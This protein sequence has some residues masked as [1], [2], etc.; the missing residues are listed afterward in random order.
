MHDNGPIIFFWAFLYR[1]MLIHIYTLTNT[2]IIWLCTVY[3]R[4]FLICKMISF[5][6]FFFFIFFPFLNVL[7]FSL[8]TLHFWDFFFSFAHFQIVFLLLLVFFLFQLV[9][10]WKR[11]T[12]WLMLSNSIWLSW[13]R[14][15]VQKKEQHQD[16]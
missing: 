14:G 2:H 6:F 9:V 5:F 11:W 10:K 12:A 16:E 1:F 4:M 13:R 7:C 3:K 15:T 8:T